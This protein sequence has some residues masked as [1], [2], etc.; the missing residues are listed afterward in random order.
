MPPYKGGWGYEWLDPREKGFLPP[1]PRVF[2]ILLAF[3]EWSRCGY[4]V[5]KSV[6]ERSNGQVKLD[7]GYPVLVAPLPDPEA[8][9]LAAGQRV[10]TSNLARASDHSASCCGEKVRSGI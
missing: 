9:E 7:V 2:L 4:E 5:K 1:N 10:S 6:E 3:A 8:D